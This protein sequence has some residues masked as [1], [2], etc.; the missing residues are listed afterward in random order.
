MRVY[1]ATS[2]DQVKQLL[3]APIE[4]VDYLTPDQ[5]EFDASVDDEAREHLISLLAA[6]DSLE[7]NQ[8]KSGFVLAIDLADEKL[9]LDLIEISLNSV[10]ALL[11][12]V[13][14]EEL[15]WFAPEEI[16]HQIDSWS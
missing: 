4:I 11:Y 3:V 6:E 2:L 5:F 13:D 7:I 9:N 1:V 14:G 15:S 16:A 12:S 8:G 10:A